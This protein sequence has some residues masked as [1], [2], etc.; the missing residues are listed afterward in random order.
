[1]DGWMDGHQCGNKYCFGGNIIQRHE[2]IKDEHEYDA[3]VRP[4][5]D[6]EYDPASHADICNEFRMVDPEA[7]TCKRIKK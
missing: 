3:D 2:H 7:G 5:E 6:M 4:H 1:M